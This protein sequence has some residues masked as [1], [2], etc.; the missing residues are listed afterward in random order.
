MLA[1][2]TKQVTFEAWDGRLVSIS[3]DTLIYIDL[4]H[5]IG[6]FGPHHFDILP[7]EY[8]LIS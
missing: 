4:E 8:R 1:F 3:P 5:E 7:S 6:L 2:I